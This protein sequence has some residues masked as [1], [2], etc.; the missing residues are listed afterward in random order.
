M[1]PNQIGNPT[2][3]PGM[4]KV[5][6]KGTPTFPKKGNVQESPYEAVPWLALLVTFSLKIL[7]TCS[8]LAGSFKF[9]KVSCIVSSEPVV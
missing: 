7:C 8:S 3:N 4:Y 5:A 1:V 2:F 6:I 9:V